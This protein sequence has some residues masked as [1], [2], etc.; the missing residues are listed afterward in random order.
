METSCGH[1]AT[2]PRDEARYFRDQRLP[3]VELLSATYRRQRF[4]RHFHDCYALGVIEQG[5]LR[6][7]YLGREHLAPAGSVSLVAPGE[8]HNGD[9]GG[10]PGWSYRMLYLAPEM[11]RAAAREAGRD[12]LPDF[13]RGVLDDPVLAAQV[14]GLHLVLEQD[15]AAGLELD[16]RLLAAL[17]RWVS[18]HAAGARGLPRAGSEPRAVRLVRECLDARFSEDIR[19]ADLASHAGMSPF[20]L[21]RVFGRS[22]GLPP[23]RYQLLRR[24][25][26]ARSRL[27]G[28]ESLAEIAL[29]AGFADQSHLTREFKRILGVPPGQYRKMLQER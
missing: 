12:A 15:G 9:A 21:V 5:G 24:V 22:T 7:D 23:A 4:A 3:G 20:H 13:S 6:F 16:S 19:L 1:A 14:R 25:E 10:G 11:V 27:Q 18:L 29:L 26:F 2:P 17:T 8:V 28:A